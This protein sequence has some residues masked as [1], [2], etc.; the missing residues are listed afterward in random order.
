MN[1]KGTSLKTI[2]SFLLGSG[3][4]YWQYKTAVCFDSCSWYPQ[5]EDVSIGIA[6][7]SWSTV[8]GAF[9]KVVEN[10]SRPGSVYSGFWA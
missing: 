7:L 2:V 1:F 8:F 3:V 4:S 9:Y 6:F 5:A 10:K